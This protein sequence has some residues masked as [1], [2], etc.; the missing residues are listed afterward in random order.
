MFSVRDLLGVGAFG[1]VLL[2]K[3]RRTREKSALK[4]IAKE[5]LSERAQGVLKNES[6]IMQTMQHE[7][8]VALKRIFEN[9][10]FFI[11]EM[12]LI[13]GGQL[14]RLLK[15]KDPAGNPRPLSDLE[16]SKVMKCLLKGVAYVHA[17]DIVHRDLKPENILLK[18]DA[19]DCQ[20]V[21][22]VDFG[23]SAE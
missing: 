20:E 14:K 17:R 15:L 2:V 7:S 6:T 21:K 3:N 8:V 16:A 22:I 23:L 13:P 4:I 19:D 11:L 18:T 1:V 10:K 5:N 12:E 9:Q